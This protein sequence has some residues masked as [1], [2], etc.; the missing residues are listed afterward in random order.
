MKKLVSLLLA[1]AMVLSLAACGSK[2]PAASGSQSEDGR[3]KLTIGIPTSVNVSDYED[4]WFTHY[5]EDR[6]DIDIDFVFFSGNSQERKTQISTMVAGKEK[7]PDILFAFGLGKEEI[8]A[9]GQGGYLVDMAPYFD[10][11]DWEY[12]KEW[13]KQ[14]IEINGEET[15]NRA[16]MSNRDPYGAMYYWPSACP[17]ATDNTYAMGFINTVWLEKLGLE[18]PKT[19]DE[20]VEVLRAFRDKDPNGNGKQDE[21]P[22]LGSTTL[23]CG[24]APTWII[25]NFGQ[26]VCDNYFYDV[27]DDGK[28]YIPYITDEYRNGVRAVRDLV[29]E[30]LLAP[31]T[32]TIK[33]KLEM[34]SVW[35]PTSGEAMTGVI[36][37]YPTSYISETSELAFQYDALPPME[38]AYT[39]VRPPAVGSGSYITTDCEDFDTACK[40]LASFVDI[41]VAHACRRGEEGV[42]FVMEVDRKSGKL[43]VNELNDVFSGSSTNK[44]WSVNGPYVGWY[45]SGSPWSGGSYNEAKDETPSGWRSGLLGKIITVNLGH[46]A[47][48][49]PKNL[50]FSVTYNE[51]EVDKNGTIYTD[52]KEYVKAMRAKFATGELD[53]DS[54]AEWN[55]YLQTIE[56]MGLATIIETTQAA[57]DR[58]H[59]TFTQNTKW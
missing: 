42:D 5:M 10:D 19:Y 56:K 7:L 16:L 25:N 26:Y 20:L 41:D 34:T 27:D 49:N 37:G 1:L 31:L 58:Q 2:T 23:Y 13:H 30:G 22:M 50:F 15:H 9:Y 46:A 24:D 39:P 33:D 28:I 51:E 12:G 4:N 53:I 55:K 18:M 44:T 14:M 45:G 8:H 48:V 57:Y 52:I 32:W 40:F 11:P 43:M 54:D 38:G 21:I 29:K 59:Y 36:F 17:S 47:E 3:K 35:T 6:L